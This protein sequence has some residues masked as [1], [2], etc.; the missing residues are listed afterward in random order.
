MDP[1]SPGTSGS[2]E[3]GGRI[4]EI[5]WADRGR[6]DSAR[7]C[8]PLAGL[9]ARVLLRRG[10]GACILARTSRHSLH[11]RSR[12]KQGNVPQTRRP[13]PSGSWG[14]G[15]ADLIDLRRQGMTEPAETRQGCLLTGRSASSMCWR[16]R[17][18]SWPTCLAL[19]GQEPIE[20]AR[21]SRKMTTCPRDHLLFSARLWSL[22]DGEPHPKRDN[23]RSQPQAT[24]DQPGRI[25]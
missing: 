4:A 11:G 7:R 19:N 14:K 23:R 5:G 6:G 15:G 9:N 1:N 12:P 20:R 17:M 25:P 24:Q 18:P 2:S 3:V 10:K 8:G 16:S 22:E 13:F 21:A